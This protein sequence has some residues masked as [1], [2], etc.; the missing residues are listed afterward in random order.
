LSAILFPHD[1]ATK[2]N[3]IVAAKTQ[4]TDWHFQLATAAAA[5]AAIAGQCHRSARGAA[6]C[7]AKGPLAGP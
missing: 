4:Q 3:P 2:K 6:R 5:S 7:G 1:A